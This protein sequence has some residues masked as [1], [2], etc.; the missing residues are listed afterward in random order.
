MSKPMDVNELI[1]RLSQLAAYDPDCYDLY[2]ES[3]GA[4][5]HMR[6]RNVELLAVLTDLAREY[7]LWAYHFD[8]DDSTANAMISR[9]RA[10]IAKAEGK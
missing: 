1:T 10:A 7:E 9:A 4:L 2:A 6:A 8:N 3:A 5:S